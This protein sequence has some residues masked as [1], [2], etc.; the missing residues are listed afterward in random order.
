VGA[1]LLTGG[2]VARAAG[3]F[4]YRYLPDGTVQ[5]DPAW[6]AANIR[7]EAV[8][9]LGPVTCHRVMLPRLRWALQ[10]VVARGLADAVDPNDFGGCY[11]PRFVGHDPAEGLSLHTWGI[12]LDLNVSGNQ[13]GTAGSIDRS[14]VAV[15]K[16]WGFAWGGDWSYTDPMHF[17]LAALTRP[18]P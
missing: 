14:V 4:R 10:E 12:A 2:S 18:L 3:S 6:V 11:V 1:A 8:P 7:T 9:V 17:E 16:K 15:L 5:P 13:R